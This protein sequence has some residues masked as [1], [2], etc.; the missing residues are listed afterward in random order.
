MTICDV[1][2]TYGINF[3]NVDKADQTKSNKALSD[4]SYLVENQTKY[5]QK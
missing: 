5:M 1:A 2:D 4:L 3:S